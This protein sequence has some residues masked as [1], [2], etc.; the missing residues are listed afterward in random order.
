MRRSKY[1]T[2]DLRDP[3]S[4]LDCVCSALV[5]FS[6]WGRGSVE[7][8]SITAEMMDFFFFL[9]F[10]VL[11]FLGDGDAREATKWTMYH[12]GSGTA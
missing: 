2:W 1:S 5:M 4:S 9:F 12:I 6:G 10:F 3:L 11:S 7:V 8:V